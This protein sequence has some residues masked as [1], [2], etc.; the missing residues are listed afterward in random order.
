MKVKSESEVAHSCPTLSDPMDCSPP[1][2]SVHGI[3]QARVLE[4]GASAFS[5][6]LVLRAINSQACLPLGHYAVINKYKR[7]NSQRGSFRVDVTLQLQAWS[8]EPFKKPR[9]TQTLAG[10]AHPAPRPE[11]I[12]RGGAGFRGRGGAGVGWP[13]AAGSREVWGPKTPACDRGQGG[14][15]EGCLSVPWL[16]GTLGKIQCPDPA[17]GPFP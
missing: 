5:G 12:V 8:C 1:G 9:T 4:W 16:P 11:G 17:A 7:K 13:A 10:S 2:S 3:F 15:R 6:K 14:L